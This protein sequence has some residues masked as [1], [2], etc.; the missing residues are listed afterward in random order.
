V[1]AGL[2]SGTGLGSNTD[3]GAKLCQANSGTSGQL[4]VTKQSKYGASVSWEG[5]RRSAG[6]ALA[7]HHRR[8]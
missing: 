6:V 3:R 1:L 2:I 8:W 5:N 7:I 4:A